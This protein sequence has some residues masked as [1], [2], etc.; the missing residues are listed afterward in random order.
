MD[1][2]E[3]L[4]RTDWVTV[5][6]V[7]GCSLIASVV[8]AMLA[9]RTARARMRKDY[10]LEDQTETVLRTLL[11]VGPPK[12]PERLRSFAALEKRVPLT[13]EKLREALLRAGA[14]RCE[15]RADGEEM[16]GLIEFHPDKL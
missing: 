13:E 6:I 9:A 7:A 1:G 14:I 4:N 10:L 2:M 8:S 5:S 15:K 12:Y 11:E 3:L 16:W